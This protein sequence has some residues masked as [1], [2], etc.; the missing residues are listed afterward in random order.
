M[1]QGKVNPTVKQVE[2]RAQKLFNEDNKTSDVALETANN[3]I[4]DQ[5]VKFESEAMIGRVNAIDPSIIAS[6]DLIILV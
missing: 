4:R 2:T 3:T 5:I 1:D 6:K